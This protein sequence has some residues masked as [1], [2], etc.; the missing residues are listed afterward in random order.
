MHTHTQHL[1]PW[2]VL[3]GFT[4]WAY[5]KQWFITDREFMKEMIEHH[6]MALFTTKH[7][8]RAA[9]HADVKALAYQIH[10]TQQEE[11]ALMKRWLRNN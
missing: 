10:L 3:C 5:R 7:R 4:I 9:E 2:F 6:A 8:I 1:W 11:V